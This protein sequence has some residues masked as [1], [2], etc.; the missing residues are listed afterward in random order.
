MSVSSEIT[1]DLQPLSAQMSLSVILNAL[2]PRKYVC[3]DRRRTVDVLCAHA[4]R[5]IPLIRG[6]VR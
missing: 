4:V 3:K 5:R 2:A 6:D 1:Q